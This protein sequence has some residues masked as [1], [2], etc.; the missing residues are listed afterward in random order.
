MQ[1]SGGRGSEPY[2]TPASR[3][4]SSTA[5]SFRTDARVI[6]LIAIAHAVSHVLQLALPPLFIF[7]KAEFD[8]SY[9]AL[10]ALMS[11]FYGASGLCQFGAGFAVDRFG[12]RPV[13]LAGMAL[14][15]ICTLLAGIAPAF[16]WLYVLAGLMG[17]GNGA[18]HPAD[19]AV[20]NARVQPSRLGHAYSL[21]GVGGSLGYAIAPVCSY[22]LGS[23]FGWRVALIVMGTAALVILGALAA[24]RRDLT[25]TG[26]RGRTVRGTIASRD[27]FRQTPILLCFAFFC[28]YN[29]GSIAVQTFAAPA[30][31]AAYAIPMAIATSAL[32][33]YLLG[34]TSGIVVGGFLATA[35]QR[36]DRV[37][38]AGLAIGACIIAL[39]AIVP[40][41]PGV[42]FPLFAMAG[43]A[44]G[45]TGPSRDMIVRKATPPGA[46]GRTYGFVYSGLD[47][48]A[49]LGPVI[50][51]ALLDHGS[52]R[53]VFVAIATCL[54]LGMAT[55]VEARR[56]AP[57][58]AAPNL[59]D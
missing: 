16:A 56:R 30:L 54:L 15:A 31:N 48:G 59:A 9:A 44:L 6:G 52:P 58:V 3:L 55:V 17:I 46:S 5:T 34:S 25:T 28:I 27:L 20:L 1:Y 50:A 4:D 10:G 18:F 2:K 22:A 36:H 45:S 37:A 32:T 12:A 26:H 57:V 38:S 11:V 43:F 21:H 51:G 53:L 49:T 42:A 33:G 14:L 41:T 39:F 24:N 19:F 8:V 29:T 47:I 7:L 35:T 23:A 13:L 40:L